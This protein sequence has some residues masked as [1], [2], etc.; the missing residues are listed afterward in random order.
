MSDWPVPLARPARLVA[1]NLAGVL[2]GLTAVLVGGETWRRLTVPFAHSATQS[3][4]V[5]GVGVMLKPHAEVRHTN[6]RDYWVAQHA[7]RLGFLDRDPQQVGAATAG[8]HVAVIGDSFVEGREVAIDD[9]LQ[10]QLQALAAER[11]PGL[12]VVATGFGRWATGQIAQLAIFDKYVHALRPKLVVLVFHSNDFQD[13]F[14]RLR[15]LNMHVPMDQMPFVV[16]AP[17]ERGGG[18]YLSLRPNPRVC[19]VS[20]QAQGLS[21]GGALWRLRAT[22]VH[23]LRAHWSAPN[24]APGFW[25]GW[26]A[27][28]CR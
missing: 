3:E 22:A 8:C 17:R 13:N 1:Y 14:A 26:R 25:R 27:P 28:A 7:N 11:L 5:A 19:T 12:D 16:A 23:A 4:F 21:G 20:T 24:A 15:A 9:K 6:Q 10:V 2:L 18:G